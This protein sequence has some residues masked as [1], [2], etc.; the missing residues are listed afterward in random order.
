VQSTTNLAQT[1]WVDLGGA[2]TA[3]NST[4]TIT[5]SVNPRGQTFYRV[6]LVP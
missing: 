5:N 3:T 6:V 2:I 4:M 1:N